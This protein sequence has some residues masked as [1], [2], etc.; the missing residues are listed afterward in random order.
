MVTKLVVA[1]GK[2]AGRTIAIKRNRLLIGRAEECDVR[3]LSEDVSRRH[4]EVVVGLIAQ[5]AGLGFMARC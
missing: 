3:P 4:C 5:S 1:S 2:N